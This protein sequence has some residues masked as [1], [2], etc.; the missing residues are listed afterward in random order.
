MG[1]DV[2]CFDGGCCQLFWGSS[3]KIFEEQKPMESGGKRKDYEGRNIGL[4]G[5]AAKKSLSMTHI[6]TQFRFSPLRNFQ[7]YMLSHRGSR[8]RIFLTSWS[9]IFSLNRD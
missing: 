8:L 4:E 1:S 6:P 7:D 9:G 2:M 3:S 5:E